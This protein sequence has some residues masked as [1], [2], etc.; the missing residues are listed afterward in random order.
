VKNY[1][2]T[3]HRNIGCTPIQAENSVDIRNELRSIA[4]LKSNEIQA[5]NNLQVGD[6]VRVL[7]RRK[8]FG[9]EKARWSKEVH[10]ISENN[11]TNFAVT[12]K[13]RRYKTYELQK[14]HAEVNENSLE[15]ETK[16][17]DV[18][19]TLE[20]ARKSRG[21]NAVDLPTGKPELRKTKAK[22]KKKKMKKVKSKRVDRT[23]IL[24]EGTFVWLKNASFDLRN[25]TDMKRATWDNPVYF[26]AKITAILPKREVRLEWYKEAKGRVYTIVPSNEPWIEGF[27]SLNPFKPKKV[28]GRGR[29]VKMLLTD[30]YYKAL[31]P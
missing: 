1:N 8:M 4:R 19:K 6:K 5:R 13:P 16:G 2:N 23:K 9:K 14:V 12:G 10:T 15:R 17:F 21:K 3:L 25:K 24:T 11:G 30:G 7:L 29:R 28:W 26:V 18:E 27:T 20:K 31:H 22:Q